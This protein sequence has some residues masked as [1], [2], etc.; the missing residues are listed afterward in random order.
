MHSKEE[1]QIFL[2]KALDP[3]Y[4]IEV[5]YTKGKIFYFTKSCVVW[6][7]KWRRP[8]PNAEGIF[9]LP[10]YS[11]ARVSCNVMLEIILRYADSTDLFTYRIIEAVRQDKNPVTLWGATL[12]T[13]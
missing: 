2:C 10:A 7:I 9:E 1:T 6:S 13:C 8:W 4:E 3:N 11:L 12:G 5:I